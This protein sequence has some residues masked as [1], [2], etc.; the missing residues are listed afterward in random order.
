MRLWGILRQ[1]EKN[2]YGGEAVEKR[3]YAKVS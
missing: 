2:G 1:G 3:G